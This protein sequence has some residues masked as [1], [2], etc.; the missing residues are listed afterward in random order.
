MDRATLK[1]SCSLSG[2]PYYPLEFRKFRHF[3]LLRMEDLSGIFST[4]GAADPLTIQGTIYCINNLEEK[5]AKDTASL[6]F[7]NIYFNK[8]L[9]LTRVSAA[10]ESVTISKESAGSIRKGQY[11]SRV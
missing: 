5:F 3:A 2:F 9:T 4:P 7:Y 11:Q 6:Y 10:L 8:K 1:N